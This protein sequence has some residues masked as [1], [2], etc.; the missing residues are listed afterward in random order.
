MISKIK[1]IWDFLTTRKKWWLG[2][3]FIILILLAGI[4][5]LTE[6]SAIAAFI[7]TIF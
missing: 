5:V 4:I 2:P 1:L 6:T 3:I 7:Y